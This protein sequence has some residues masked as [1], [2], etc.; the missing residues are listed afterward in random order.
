MLNYR[1]VLVEESKLDGIR[2]RA[3]Y[4]LLAIYTARN[5]SAYAIDFLDLHETII[6]IDV[7][8]YE[9]ARN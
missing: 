6:Y 7:V 8:N 4:S 9:L 5:T 1:C 3:T 2:L